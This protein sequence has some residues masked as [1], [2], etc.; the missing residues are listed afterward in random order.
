MTDVEAQSADT[1]TVSTPGQPAQSTLATAVVQM[2][3]TGL[4]HNPSAT[5]LTSMT[6]SG[7]T[8]SQ[9]AAA[10]VSSQ[11]FA[12]VNTGGV[13]VDPNA[14]ANPTVINSLFQHNLGHLPTDATLANFKGLTNEQAFLAI[15]TSNSSDTNSSVF[16]SYLTRYSTPVSILLAALIIGVAIA[17]HAS[18]PIRHGGILA[19]RASAWLRDHF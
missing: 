1:I 3:E 16:N 9:L 10:F 15:A 19:S 6:S 8:E 2:F 14:P 7:L 12:D 11:A 4:G 5:T 18:I 17:T 13:R